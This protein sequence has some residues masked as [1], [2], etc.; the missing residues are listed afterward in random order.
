MSPTSHIPSKSIS[1]PS[2]LK[3]Y[4]PEKQSSQVSPSLSEHTKIKLSDESFSSNAPSL[5]SSLSPASQ[6]PSAS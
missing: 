3:L 6:A 1:L 4:V 5:S 2:L